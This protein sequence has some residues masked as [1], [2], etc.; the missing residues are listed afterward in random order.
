MRKITLQIIC[1]ICIVSLASA[2][3]NADTRFNGLDTAF[4]RVLKEF[5]TAG[6]VVA[7]VEK[8]KI[9]YSKGFGYRNYES[10]LPVTT[11]TLFAIGSC[12]KAFTSS[13]LGLLRQENKIDFDK[14]VRNYLPELKFYNDELNNK[15]TLR[16]MMCHRTG[17]PRHDYSWYFFTTPSRDS[18]IQRIQYLEPSAG[19]R[20]KWQYNNFMFLVQGAVAEKIT[21]KTWEENIKQRIFQ[22]LGMTTSM[23]SVD[24]MK[25]NEDAAIGYGLE[26]DTVISKTDYFHIDA[27]GPAGSINSNANEM[28]NWVMTWLNHGKFNGK[29]ILPDSYVTEA[30]S[31]QMAIGGSSSLPAKEHP[32]LFLADYGFGWILSSYRGHFSV[33]HGG[34]IDGFSASTS[35][36]PTDSVGIVVLV[37]QSNS[38]VTSVVRNIMADRVLKLKQTDWTTDLKKALEKNRL[39]AIAGEKAKISGRKPNTKPTHELKDYSGLFKNSGYGVMDVYVSHDSLFVSFGDH[40]LWLRHYHYD[41]FEPI[42]REANGFDTTE[43]NLPAQFQMNLAGDIESVSFPFEPALKDP[44][45]FSRIPRP[46]TVNKDSLLKFA[47]EYDF[48]GVTAIVS[49]RN[50]KNLFLSVPGQPEYELVQIEENKF[51]I[52]SFSGYTI[53]FTTN[54]SNEVIELVSI[55]PNGTYKATRKK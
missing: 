50:D 54:A 46:K 2:Q 30:M 22:P 49:L 36:F 28:S 27:M 19:L 1:C 42:A 18:L 14:P 37:N 53:L 45:T 25:K 23:F 12:T 15:V 55:Q 31:A 35:F 38:G 16:D 33:G 5:H 4:A 13:L 6:F 3:K 7:V 48:N 24:E 52:K 40:N 9:V 17:L 21:G 8:N 34:N 44:I 51:N 26:K 32:D 11:N 41:M 20:E 47:G 29:Q 10:K 43:T 39:N